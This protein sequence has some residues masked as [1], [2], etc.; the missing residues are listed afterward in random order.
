MKFIFNIAGI[1]LLLAPACARAPTP[2]L[3]SGEGSDAERVVALL[4]YVS[5]DYALNAKDGVPVSRDEY[6][7]QLRF[8]GDA[9]RLAARLLG[10]GGEREPLGR[11]MADMEA[12]VRAKATP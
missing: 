8:A 6:E 7:E 1:L 11:R 10:P 9:R 2:A 4:D 3:P 12:R 5:G